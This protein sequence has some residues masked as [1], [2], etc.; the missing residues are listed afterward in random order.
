MFSGVIRDTARV[1]AI[2]SGENGAVLRLASSV[3]SSESLSLRPLKVGDSISISGVC[4]TA[5]AFDA[6]QEEADFDIAS[7][8]LRRTTLGTLKPGETCHLETS[9][10]LGDSIDGHFVFGHVDTTARLLSKIVEG[11]TIRF[12]FSLSPEIASKVA[13]KGSISLDGVSLTVGEVTDQSFSV[14]LIPHTLQN[15]RFGELQPGELVNVEVD[16]LAR[17]AERVIQFSRGDV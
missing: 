8:T 13:V 7:E 5:V 1:S 15:T 16:M 3:F 6:A 11:E 10:K 4:L 17:Y 12:E 2:E 9:L 14:Y